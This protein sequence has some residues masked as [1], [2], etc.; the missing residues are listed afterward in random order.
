MKVTST[1]VP[2]KYYPNHRNSTHI[3]NSPR[4]FKQNVAKSA[5]NGTHV[6]FLSSDFFRKLPIH[7]IKSASSLV[8]SQITEQSSSIFAPTHEIRRAVFRFVE[9][10]PAS[11]RSKYCLLWIFWLQTWWCM[12]CLIFTSLPHFASSPYPLSSPRVI[13]RWLL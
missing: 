2:L 13:R 11:I 1:L 7:Y 9:R 6:P 3:L 12:F 5:N 10:Q 4:H 8:S